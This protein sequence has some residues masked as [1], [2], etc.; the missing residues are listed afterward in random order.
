MIKYVRFRLR[1]IEVSPAVARQSGM[2]REPRGDS[3]VI[4]RAEASGR[5]CLQ[6][7]QFNKNQ[8]GRRDC[9]NVPA[10]I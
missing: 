4:S 7:R 3:A 8:K 2:N 9:P 6:L 5:P 10:S 1:R